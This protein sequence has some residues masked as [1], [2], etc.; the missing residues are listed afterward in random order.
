MLKISSVRVIEVQEVAREELSLIKAFLL[1]S[2]KPLS[3]NFTLECI[4][5]RTGQRTNQ[6]NV[7]G[8]HLI[9]AAQAPCISTA[10]LSLIDCITK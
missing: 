10:L 3:V 7:T 2:K 1:E 8:K 5:C 6:N 9:T 4:V